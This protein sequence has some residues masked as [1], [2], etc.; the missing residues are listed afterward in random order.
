MLF[1]QVKI[2][3]FRP[4]ARCTID[5]SVV[6]VYAW[7]FENGPPDSFPREYRGFFIHSATDSLST[8]SLLTKTAGHDRQRLC[9]K[10]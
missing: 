10:E 3:S 2:C 5:I 7:I 9:S 1:L 6:F 4:K 8:H